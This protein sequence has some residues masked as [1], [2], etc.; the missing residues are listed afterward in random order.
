MKINKQKEKFQ[1]VLDEVELQMILVAVTESPK[2]PV[3]KIGLKMIE[4]LKK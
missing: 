4:A 1:I 3:R 2:L